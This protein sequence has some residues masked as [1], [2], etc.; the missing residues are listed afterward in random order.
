MGEKC[1]FPDNCAIKIGD[2]EVDP[3]IY[4]EIETVEN[5]TVHILKCKKCGH[6]EIEWERTESS[7]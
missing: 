4:E 2:Y 6:I 1:K 7:Q 3:C 5:C